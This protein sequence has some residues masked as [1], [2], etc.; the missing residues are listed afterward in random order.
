MSF[1]GF[2]PAAFEFYERLE[3]DNTKAFWQANKATYDSA[4]R[5]PMAELCEE[6]TEYG[7]FHL[8]RPYNDVRFAKNR[9]PY[10]TAQGAYGETEGGAGYYVQVST[11]GLRAGA[12]YYGM[13]RD[14]LERYRAAVDDDA[15]G[16]GLLGI[17]ADL[18]AAGF[19][20]GAREQVKTAPRGYRKD[21]PRVELLRRKGSH[22]TRLWP[23]GPRWI[24]APAAVDRV[25]GAFEATV[26]LCRW[27]DEHVGPSTLPPPDAA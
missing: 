10:K 19:E 23:R 22:A 21:H 7:P 6:L 24:H 8:F 18:V 12:G 26:P 14:Q 4:V 17:E 15:A 1:R 5:T 2:P 11:E 3:A 16:P 25:R 9:P 27:L 13:A 20:V